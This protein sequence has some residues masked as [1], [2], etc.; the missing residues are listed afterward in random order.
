MRPIAVFL[1]LAAVLFA[2]GD[3]GRIT[4]RVVDPSGA[5]VVGAQIT[6]TE[7]DTGVA[8]KAVSSATGVYAAAFLPPGRYAVTSSLEGFKTYRRA[9]IEVATGETIPLD[10][11]LELGA[12]SDT[13]V[14]QD[15]LP[16]LESSTSD[17]GQLI[18][19][20]AVAEMPLNGRR[21]LAL[22]ALSA[23]TVWVDYGGEA[24]PSFSLAGGRVQSQGF[25]LDG[26]SVQN[27]RSGVGQ[28]SIDPPVEVIREFR[29]IQN[30]YPAEFGGSAGG[31]VVST[32]K[33]GTNQFHGSA[34]EYFRND[35]LDARNFFAATNPP[36]RYHLFG[37][38]LGGP[39]RRNRTHFFAGYEGTRRGT[40]GVTT[41]TVPT[42]EQR[43]GDFSRTTN[44]AGALIRIFDP[45]SNRVVSGRNVRDPFPGNVIPAGRLDPVA[46]KLMAYYPQPNR[47][48]SNAAG[49]NNFSSN[50]VS[51]FNRNNITAKVNHVFSDRNRA[52]V[53]WVYNRDPISFSSVYPNPIAGTQND[54]QRYQ[55]T[56]LFSD[57][58]TFT[59]RLMTDLRVDMST[60]LTHS[61]SP[62]LGSNGPELLGLKGVPSGAFPT[63]SA[64][65]I[66]GLGSATHERSG[67]PSIQQQYVNGW[68]YVRGSHI[69][70]FGGEVRGSPRAEVVRG[71]ISGNFGFGTQPTALEGTANTGLGLASLLVGFPNTFSM[72]ATD[73]LDRRMFYLA[74][75]VQDDWKLH[76]DLT[77]NLGVR[78]E[79]DTPMSDANDAMNGF[80]P[81]AVNPVSRTR[82]VVRFAGKD[83]WP[84]YAY[85]ADWNNFGPRFG[86]AWQPWGTRK[87]VIRGGFGILY[88][89][90]FDHAV[91]NNASLGFE[92][93]AS[94][95]TPDNG[96]TAPFLLRNG[97]PAVQLGR[98]ELTSGFG[99][100]EVGKNPTTSVQFFERNRRTGYSQQFNF[101]IQRELPRGVMV[102]ATL[103]GNLSRKLGMEGVNIN[104]IHP[105]LIEAVRPAGV[106][107]QAYRPFPQ[108]N[109]VGLIAATYGAS[110]YYAGVFKAEKRFAKGYSF[111]AT[112]TWSK[113]IGNLD[114][115]SGDLGAAQATSDYYNR[116]LDKGPDALDIRRRFTWSSVFELPGRRRL[117]RVLGGWKIGAIALVQSGG[118]FTATTQTNTTNVFSA[119]AQRANLLRNPNL[120]NSQKS[121]TRWFDTSAFELPAP[122][123]FGTAGRGILRADGRLNFDFSLNKDFKLR[124]SVDMQF[125]AETFNAFN[126]ADFGLP[127]SGLGG[128]GFGVINS[129]TDARIV[130]FGLRLSF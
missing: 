91:P 99:A 66:S 34:F 117:G 81:D 33:S 55:T 57:S 49:V 47:A 13:V 44:A 79:T 76:P 80:D 121:L 8:Y 106:F 129:A 84:R 118:A 53:R 105:S 68:M 86:F 72:R 19:S 31:L 21:A 42:P 82:G 50:M 48:P 112:Y 38:T 10:I 29:V 20:T 63:F 60:A 123:T 5:V 12:A 111:L 70:K 35:K 67:S 95:T 28:V 113:N 93:S 39:I 74:G 107:R 11:H 85:E 94:L 14:V 37:T 9:G 119:G 3:S 116:R 90:P 78:W 101:G 69:I 27:A 77:L 87:M 1:S 75:Y 64:S 103:L 120:P 128:P 98:Q 32:T 104:Q 102:D 52:Y 97:V 108:F 71:S 110:N 40:G 65:G 2:Q 15:T 83:G 73:P 100:V 7:Q 62:G 46:V 124:E 41:L 16:L 61:V 54:T 17:V 36:L 22:V 122:F 43:A 45:S 58:H 26:G 125:R 92:T 23:A 89:H 30:T 18:E 25:W 114:A 96:V 115:I 109:S 127:G 4:G 6:A 88:A 59:P 126:H 51:R 130:Q 24:K 56:L